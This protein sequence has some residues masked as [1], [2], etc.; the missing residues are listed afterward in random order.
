M[1]KKVIYNLDHPLK[2]VDFKHYIISLIKPKYFVDNI[3]ISY[4]SQY[5]TCVPNDS[6]LMKPYILY[7]ISI[8]PIKCEKHLK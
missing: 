3:K 4:D 6:D 2:M 1:Y 5:E 8:I 7:N